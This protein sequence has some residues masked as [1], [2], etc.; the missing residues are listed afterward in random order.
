MD[1]TALC[2][3][4]IQTIIDISIKVSENALTWLSKQPQMLEI[5]FILGDSSGLHHKLR[6][7]SC[8]YFVIK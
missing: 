8:S 7:Y 6:Q 3:P 5:L 1:H 2:T 4:F